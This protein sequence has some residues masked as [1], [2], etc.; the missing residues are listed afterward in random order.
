MILSYDARMNY[1]KEA[2]ATLRRA[3]ELGDDA[4][5]LG[6]AALALAAIEKPDA[7][8]ALY[9]QHLAILAE[10]MR[11][12]GK[13]TRLEDQL[14][15]LRR[16][17]V[18][19]HKYQGDDNHAEDA[20][21]TNLM[22]VIDRRRGSPVALGVLYLHVAATMGW[23]MTGIDLAGHFL[24]R[25]SA[26]DGSVV[27]DPF[28]AAQTCQIEEVDSSLLDEEDEMDLVEILEE[29]SPLDFSSDM[30][31]PISR[32]D[33]LLRLQHQVKRRQLAQDRVEPAIKTLQ[34]MILFAPRRQELWRELGYLQAERGHIRAAITSLEVVRDLAT[35]PSPVQQTDGMIRELRWRLN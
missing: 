26:R 2:L 17:I 20:R 33:V 23:A 9:R 6:E 34:S 35:G 8:L 19:Q 13:L 12:E 11:A 18:V 27:I 15:V 29:S 10:Q 3:G 21:A 1:Q 5:N 30:L 28:R 25:L 32:R 16:V 4:I 14:R 22:D 24:L 7:N 31:R